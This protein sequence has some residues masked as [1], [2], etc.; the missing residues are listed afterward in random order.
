MVD[1]SCV[2]IG[3]FIDSTDADSAMLVYSGEDMQTHLRR[4]RD[5]I[6]VGHW[7]QVRDVP[8]DAAAVAML[9]ALRAGGL[10]DAY[11]NV[12][13]DEGIKISL[14]LFV[15]L[16]RAE[17]VKLRARSLGLAAEVSPRTRESDV[18]YVDI[19]LPPSKGVGAIVE[20]YGK[21][22]VLLRDDA[23]CPK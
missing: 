6:F 2:T 5:L 19:G 23:T 16:K 22:R 14:G 10:S 13:D 15:E 4:T 21:D 9:S 11:K 18:L 7:V 3:P 17:K 12:T 8:D 20:K 1:R